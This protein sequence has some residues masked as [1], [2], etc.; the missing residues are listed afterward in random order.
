MRYVKK[1]ETEDVEVVKQD[2]ID[3]YKNII[4][5]YYEYYELF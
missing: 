5:E 2:Y 4:K 3:N 1:L